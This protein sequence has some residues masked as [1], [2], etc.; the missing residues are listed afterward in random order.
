MCKKVFKKADVLRKHKR[1]HASHKPV[2]VCPRDDCQAYF[3]TTFNLEHHIRKVH[4]KLFKYKCCF[5]DCPRMFAMRVSNK[6]SIKGLVLNVSQLIFFVRLPSFLSSTGEH[7]QTPAPSWCKCHRSEGK[8]GVG[9]LKPTHGAR[10]IMD[11][12][13]NP[14]KAFVIWPVRV[15]DFESP[16]LTETSAA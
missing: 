15:C 10:Q 16:I 13:W 2:L 9:F 11:F 5:P 14:F 12:S 7:E 8:C 3:S 1:S 6:S 4:L